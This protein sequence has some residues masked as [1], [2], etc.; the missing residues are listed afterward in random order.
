PE[1][2]HLAFWPEADEAL[3]DQRVMDDMRLAQRL[4]SLGHA[5][6]NSANLKV[7]QPLAEAVF[8]VRSDAERA[9]VDALAATIADELNVKQVRV[10]NNASDMVSYSLNPLPM[11]LGR[12]L[13]GDFPKVQRALRE[14]APEDVRR[15]ARALL[16]GETISVT[17]DGQTYELTGE[18]V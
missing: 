14:G 10:A 12:Q 9:A 13:K 18:Q 5:A 6:R 3:I 4:V 7:R 8:V 1:S 16:A 2:V 17:V 15:W 11:V